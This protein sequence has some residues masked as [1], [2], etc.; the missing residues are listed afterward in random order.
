MI[1]MTEA[2][3][4]WEKISNVKTHEPYFTDEF[5][6]T[7]GQVV[8]HH[9]PNRCYIV[10]MVEGKFVRKEFEIARDLFRDKMYAAVG[11]INEEAN[12]PV[13]TKWMRS[14][15][16]RP[17]KRS[18]NLLERVDMLMDEEIFPLFDLLRDPGSGPYVAFLKGILKKDYGITL[19]PKCNQ[20]VIVRG[21]CSHC[22][23]S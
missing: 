3:S 6:V 9:A 1:S 14:P 12:S 18:Y 19:C 22:E 8:Y 15:K 23:H 10:T 2:I 13:E 21:R 7:V 4:A 5:V 17:K 16:L 20:S 11:I